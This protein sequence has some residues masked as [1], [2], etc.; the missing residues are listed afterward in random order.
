MNADQRIEVLVTRLLDLDA[1]KRFE[2]MLALGELKDPGALQPLLALIL[3]DPDEDIRKNAAW[4]VEMLIREQKIRFMEAGEPL[5]LAL[6]NANAKI[7]GHAAVALSRIYGEHE[8]DQIVAPKIIGL[9]SDPDAFVRYQAAF[10]MVKLGDER[11]RAALTAL[12]S[13]SDAGVRDMAERALATLDIN[14]GL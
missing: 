3:I 2:T 11:A 13:D 14:Q 5:L 12:L 9:L 1:D 7:R 10:W 4:V 6:E 8:T